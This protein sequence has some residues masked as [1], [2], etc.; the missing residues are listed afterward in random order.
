MWFEKKKCPFPRFRDFRFCPILEIK[1]LETSETFRLLQFFGSRKI[2]PG[3]TPTRKIP[4]HQTTPWKI[5]PRKILTQKIPTLNIPTHFINCLSSLF[6]HLILRPQMGREC[7]W[8]LPRI[9]NFDMS[10]TAQCSH[11]RK[12]SNNQRK[13]TMS[14][15]R[16]PSWNLSF[17]NIECC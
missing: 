2:L 3:K 17:V 11:L 4:T 6:L 10:R 7:T 15:D 13:L 9:K 5:S 16:F 12:N 8:H 1:N 14:S